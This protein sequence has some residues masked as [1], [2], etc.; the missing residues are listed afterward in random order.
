MSRILILYTFIFFLF[1]PL[2]AQEALDSMEVSPLLETSVTEVEALAPGDPELIVPTILLEVEEE[3]L[4]LLEAPLP[5]DED[6]VFSALTLP[7]PDAPDLVIS[8]LELEVP[9][10]SPQSI[11]LPLA[12]TE[13]KRE[14]FFS[15]G[16]IGGGNSSHI[17]GNIVLYKLGD[18]PRFELQFF[19][20]GLNGFSGHQAGEGYSFRREILSGTLEFEKNGFYSDTGLIYN[21]TSLGLQDQSGFSD[22]TLRKYSLDTSLEAA[23]TGVWSLQGQVYAGA[24]DQWLS[25]D[26]PPRFSG[27]SISPVGSLLYD[28]GNLDFDFSVKYIWENL[29][30]VDVDSTDL[31]EFRAAARLKRELP[32]GLSLS[33]DLGV[34]WE[35]GVLLD[36]PASVT[37]QG[38]SGHRFFFH[39]SAARVVEH[40]SIADIWDKYIYLKPGDTNGDIDVLSPLVGWTGNL[41]GRWT[42]FDNLSLEAGTE[43][44]YLENG[45]IPLS[46]DTDG[47]YPFQRGELNN[48]SASLSGQLE[49]SGPF[50]LKAGWKG[51]LFLDPDPLVP[52]HRIEGAFSW[53]PS[54]GAAGASIIGSLDI[55]SE[56]QELFT[57]QWIPRIGFSGFYRLSPGIRLIIDGEDLLAPL[58]DSGRQIWDK[59]NDIGFEVTLKVGISL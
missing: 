4:S 34:V 22:L 7:L 54:R 19:H 58:L 10:P 43:Y 18:D 13:E 56:T 25:G 3:Q 6:S 41:Q 8:P 57:T 42:P 21:E 15:E 45:I 37:F 50:V 38:D 14:Y 1:L 39:F 23:V 40:I 27:V 5:G 32:K 59:Y 26:N 52:L 2:G 17:L 46:S 48:F 30:M 16:L 44:R 9:G 36:F 24:A 20:E 51:Q 47:L 35:P 49:A 11:S 55:Y 33:G 12:D 29:S 53:L 28:S 31:H